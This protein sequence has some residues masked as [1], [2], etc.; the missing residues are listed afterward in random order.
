MYTMVADKFVVTNA[1]TPQYTSAVEMGNDNAVYYELTIFTL[2]GATDLT[3]TLE[4]S[5]DLENWSNPNDTPTAYNSIGYKQ[6]KV[7]SSAG[8]ASRY[9][10]LKAAV[11]GTG[12][13]IFAGGI[14]T[15]SL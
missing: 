1:N 11:T 13:V 4:E 9:V 7:P 12:T 6:K 2:G 14:N 3:I 5:N 8:I 10:R 15:A